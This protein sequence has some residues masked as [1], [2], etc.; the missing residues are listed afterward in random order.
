[1]CTI[2][3]YDDRLMENLKQVTASFQEKED[4]EDTQK[5]KTW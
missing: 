2:M 4:D 5:V 1:M 3:W